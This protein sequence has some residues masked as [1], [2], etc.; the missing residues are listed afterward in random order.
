MILTEVEN[1]LSIARSRVVINSNF[2]VIT[3]NVNSILELVNISDRSIDVNSVLITKAG[4]ES[5]TTEVLFKS[6]GSGIFGGNLSVKNN[7]DVQNITA[8][9]SIILKDGNF[10]MEGNSSTLDTKGSLS[11]RGEFI[12]SYGDNTVIPMN[13]NVNNTLTSVQGFPSRSVGLVS[14]KGK[15]LAYF[16]WTGRNANTVNTWHNHV[17]L[18]TT[19]IKD[20]H[21]L[22]VFSIFPEVSS[23]N[24]VYKIIN[25]PAPSILNIAHTESIQF[26]KSYDSAEFIF[27][28]STSAWILTNLNG[29]FV[30]PNN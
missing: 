15:S 14:V 23:V 17:M 18:D 29:A 7:L 11:V 21:K 13:F 1:R 24:D 16:S 5:D 27:N 30:Q 9:K 20:S 12:L 22:I 3:E 26:T 25:G 28:E 2:S 4:S 19:N 8:K 6:N 10:T